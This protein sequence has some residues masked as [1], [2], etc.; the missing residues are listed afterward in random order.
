M[1]KEKHLFSELRK[2]C[3]LSLLMITS[4][5]LMF[6]QVRVTGVVTDADGETLVGVNVIERGTAHGTIT[7]IDG[8]FALDVASPNSYLVFSYVGFTTQEVQVGNTRNFNIVLQLD[9]ETLEEIVVVGY[10]T[11]AKKDITGSVAVVNTEDL[12]I[13]SGSSATQQL[14]ET[15]VFIGQTGSPVLQ[16]WFVSVV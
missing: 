3:L 2:L 13:T 5:G 12:L 1:Q 7:D 11:Q 14:Q 10:G 4:A 16:Q 8:K 15:P 6:A 9:M